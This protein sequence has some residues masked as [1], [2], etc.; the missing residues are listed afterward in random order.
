MTGERFGST[1]IAFRFG[2]PRNT[3]TDEGPSRTHAPQVSGSLPVYRWTLA[4]ARPTA[5]HTRAGRPCVA[6]V[7]FSSVGQLRYPVSCIYTRVNR[8]LPCLLASTAV[9]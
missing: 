5:R 9:G 6:M 2:T 8:G 7:Y 4:V 3:R 1:T